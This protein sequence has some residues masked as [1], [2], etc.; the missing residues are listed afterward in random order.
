MSKTGCSKNS[1]ADASPTVYLSSSA[2]SAQ[3]GN[4]SSINLILRAF[5]SE[6][7]FGVGFL[8]T[9]AIPTRSV[10]VH[11]GLHLDLE[12]IPFVVH[13]R[14][15]VHV[16]LRTRV[17]EPVHQEELGATFSLG[18]PLGRVGPHDAVIKPEYSVLGGVHRDP[19]DELFHLVLRVGWLTRSYSL[20]STLFSNYSSFGLRVVRRVWWTRL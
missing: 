12:T 13:R 10:Y 4:R 20:R 15:V 14:V 18:S 6:H 9:S 1:F 8:L 5:V 7:I 3:P 16:A 19:L 17:H 11:S 2:T